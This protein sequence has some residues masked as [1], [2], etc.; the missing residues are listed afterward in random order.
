[1]KSKFTLP[2]SQD[3]LLKGYIY[4]PDKDAEAII[5][6][7]HGMAEH[8]KRYDNFAKF[9]SSNNIIVLGYD[10]RGHGETLT[11][12]EDMG[13]MSD[14]DNFEAMIGDLLSIVNY[15]KQLFTKLP[16]YIIGHS[17][18]S[19]ILQRYIQLYGNSINGAILSG[20]ALNK[21]LLIDVGYFLA[22]LITKFRG[23][24]YRSKLMDKL[25]LGPFNKPFKPNRTSVDW[26]SRDE[27]VV[28][29]YVED[30]LCGKL[31]T[32]SYFL[33]LTKNFK[34]LNRN[35]ELIPKNLPILM[36]SGSNDPVGGCGKTVTK[37]HNKLKQIGITDLTFKLYEGGRHEMLNEINKEE[38]Y[39][40]IKKWLKQHIANLS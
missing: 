4:T 35:Y 1:M 27:K 33:D 38:V 13:Y 29:K 28:D 18:G 15:A 23:R 9:L 25:S 34:N 8:I 21:G 16:I 39:E 40:D 7:C 37:L 6:I 30:P 10:Q 20:S 36:F 19:F 32:V 24:R 3:T 2:V 11:T 5:V 26:L 14:I 17:M 31:F 22:C 12:Q